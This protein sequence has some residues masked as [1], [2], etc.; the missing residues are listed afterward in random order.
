MTNL[1]GKTALVV[2]ASR[3]LGRGIALA[4]DKAGAPVVAIA[5]NPAALA[6]LAAAGT[7]IRVEATDAASEE[8]ASALIGRWPALRRAACIQSG[9]APLAT[10]RITRP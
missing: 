5:R 7:G 4:L 9:D 1:A 3:G 10:P 6:E 2:G 8:A